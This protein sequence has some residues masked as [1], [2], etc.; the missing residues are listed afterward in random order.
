[1][2][3]KGSQ[4]GGAA[5]LAAHLMRLDENDHV[6]LHELRGVSA[7]TLRGALRE[8]EAVAKGTRCRQHMFSLSLSPPENEVVP[9]A[10]F[11][12]ALE[13]IE[14]KLGLSGQPRAVV[15]HEKEGRRH[16]HAV[17]SRIDV[18]KMTAINLA[19]F[20]RRLSEVSREL[21]LDNSWRLPNGLRDQANRNPMNFSREEWQQAKRTKQDPQALKLLFRECWAASDS[22]EALKGALD[23]K[24]FLLARGDR[25]GFV[26]VDWRC[27]PYSLSR[28]TGETA[29]A[30]KNR[31]S[32]VAD[33]PNI[34]DAQAMIAARMSERLIR[35]LRE[36]EA[37]LAESAVRLRAQKDALRH[38]QRA[39]RQAQR[40][41][42]EA[43]EIDEVRLRAA[44][45]RHGLGGLWDLVSGKTRRIRRQ[46]EKE[47]EAAAARDQDE[48]DRLATRQLGERRPLRQ[49][50]RE[51]RRRAAGR[52]AELRQDIGRYLGSP[53]AGSE[54]PDVECHVAHA[55]DAKPVDRGRWSRAVAGLSPDP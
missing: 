31:V 8:M 22:G 13:R 18:E 21:Y 48:Q 45:F 3:L 11:E 9:V 42:Q 4:R 41:R 25:R 6:E 29:K 24:G 17:W 40:A 1:M 37:A 43:R 34:T 54:V 16:A 36:E 23:E 19:F 5:K 39:E 7:G 46:N 26:A 14:T 2:I 47:A 50:E 20:K 35:F 10:V 53:L 38:R 49:E 33:L 44:R 27:E 30:V 15:F 12:A 52:T 32:D 55:P 51:V 28:W